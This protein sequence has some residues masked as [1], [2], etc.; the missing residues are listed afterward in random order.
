MQCGLNLWLGWIKFKG[1]AFLDSLDHQPEI[2]FDLF[3]EP[4][5]L[6]KI[7]AIHRL[8]VQPEIHL[9]LVLLL[10]ESLVDWLHLELSCY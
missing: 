9:L 8:L 5:D 1:L 2:A 10:V 3:L 6:S 7:L 4:G